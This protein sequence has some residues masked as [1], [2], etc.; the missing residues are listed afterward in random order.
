MF[1]RERGARLPNGSLFSL[2]WRPEFTST[3]S[4]SSAAARAHPGAG[5]DDEIAALELETHYLAR[6]LDFLIFGCADVDQ[7]RSRPI[8]EVGPSRLPLHFKFNRRRSDR[9][10]RQEPADHVGR[11]L[12]PLG[13]RIH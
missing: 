11:F 3:G 5:V 4:V 12:E 2:Y 8:D 1:V 13:E 10:F 6:F 9:S 7:A